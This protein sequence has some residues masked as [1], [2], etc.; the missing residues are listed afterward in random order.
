MKKNIFIQNMEQ[1][2]YAE[3]TKP[4]YEPVPR[5]PLGVENCGNARIFMQ[6]KS[7]ETTHRGFV[8]MYVDEGEG[9]ISF[10]NKHISLKKGNLLCYRATN[11]IIKLTALNQ[12]WSYK[13]IDIN[14]DASLFYYREIC[15]DM[16]PSAVI[17]NMPP[18]TFFH[19][20]NRLI[21]NLLIESKSACFKNASVLTEFLTTILSGPEALPREEGK[22]AKNFATLFTYMEKH[23]FNPLTIDDLA[24][25]FGFSKY[26]FIR[27]FQEYTGVSPMKYLCK[28][29]IGKAA[30]SL[31]LS[32]R[33]VD[34]IA[35]I[36]GYN[37]TSHFISY[38]KENTNMT[39]LQYRKNYKK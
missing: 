29:R 16:F 9:I 34:E 38:F 2:R 20:Y 4:L 31:V 14:G 30:E 17:Y 8:C 28:L 7:M 1:Q 33:S 3:I 26:H 25:V 37:S 18:D 13:W 36:V 32:D 39:P 22:Y 6:F 5:I 23:Y 19:Y 27:V 21:K 12:S 11:A 24:A 10:E 35:R 15:K